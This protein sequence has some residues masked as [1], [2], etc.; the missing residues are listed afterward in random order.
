MPLFSFFY[1]STFFGGKESGEKETARTVPP[2]SKFSLHSLK[3][4]SSLRSDTNFLNAHS[5]QF[6]VAGS[7]VRGYIVYFLSML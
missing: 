3:V 5:A 6:A 2:A 4:Q 7:L 1:F